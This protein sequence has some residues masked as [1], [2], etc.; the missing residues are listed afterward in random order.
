MIGR[1]LVA[2]SS[3]LGLALLSGCFV[4]TERPAPRDYPRIDGAD[5][6]CARDNWWELEADVS[7]PDG[8][9]AV[10]FV[11]VEVTEVWWDSWTGEESWTWLGD[12]DLGYVG[13]GIW[14]AE[15]PSSRSFLDCG[16]PYEYDLRFVAE[17]IDGDLDTFTITR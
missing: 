10:D 6:W 11:W 12:V 4:L 8:V 9:R 16:W 17:D 15:E 2:A 13:D 5:A 7:H 3:A 1:A 14:Y